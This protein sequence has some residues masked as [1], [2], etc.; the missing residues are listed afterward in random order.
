MVLDETMNAGSQNW[1]IFTGFLQRPYMPGCIFAWRGTW[2]VAYEIK[3]FL[4]FL[5]LK[6]ISALLSHFLLRAT[7][8]ERKQ[9][10]EKHSSTTAGREPKPNS[11]SAV[12]RTHLRLLEGIP[13]ARTSLPK[14]PIS[15]FFV[16]LKP[17]HETRDCPLPS[18]FFN[19]LRDSEL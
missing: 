14:F 4:P 3:P 5:F 10:K 12:P 8:S 7:Q 2:T 15:T 6:K 9:S 18:L 13:S 19:L 16:R 17:A 1:Y 11:S